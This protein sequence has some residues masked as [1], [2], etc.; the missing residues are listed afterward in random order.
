MSRLA[1]LATDR[2]GSM[3]V[4]TALVAPVLVLLGL[5]AFEVSMMVARQ[6][7]LQSAA[8]DAAAIVMAARPQTPAQFNAIGDV[9]RQ[10]AGLTRDEVSIAPVYR[11]GIEHG[12]VADPASCGDHENVSTMLRISMTER[13]SPLWASF[14]VGGPL[15]FRVTRTVQLS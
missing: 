3:A 6:N 2:R 10:S 9:V 1:N 14:G 5:G 11:C 13:Y 4:E 12:Q 8:A 15:T 7:E